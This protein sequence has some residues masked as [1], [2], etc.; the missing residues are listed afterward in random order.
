[1]SKTKDE[2][3][4]V[5]YNSVINALNCLKYSSVVKNLEQYLCPLKACME[6]SQDKWDTTVLSYVRA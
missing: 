6:T 1:M 4:L 5:T 2:E 3:P